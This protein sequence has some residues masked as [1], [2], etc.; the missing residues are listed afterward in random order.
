MT[1]ILYGPNR[2]LYPRS[3]LQNIYTLIVL[4]QL[5]KFTLIKPLRSATTGL[6]I[7]YIE[8]NTFQTFGVPESIHILIMVPSLRPE[9]LDRF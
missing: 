3:K 5:T 1:A 6:I 4:D 7:T 2:S 8:E 9:N